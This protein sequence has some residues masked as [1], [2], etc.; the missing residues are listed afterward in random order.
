MFLAAL[1]VCALAHSP[2][3]TLLL[4]LTR[5][6]A[7]GRAVSAVAYDPKPPDEIYAATVDGVFASSDGVKSGRRH[8]HLRSPLRR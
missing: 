7:L 4:R 6:R 3:I 2:P 1:A 5:R 8:S